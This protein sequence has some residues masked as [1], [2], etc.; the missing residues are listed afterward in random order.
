MMINIGPLQQRGKEEKE[1]EENSS[2][3]M[4]MDHS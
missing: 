4:V 1:E 3:D 2:I